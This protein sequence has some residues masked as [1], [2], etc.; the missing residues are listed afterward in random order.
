MNVA[1]DL[2]GIVSV[3][4]TREM[5]KVVYNPTLDVLRAV[6][7]FEVVAYHARALRWPGGFLGV[8]LFFCLSGFLISAILISEFLSSGR[9][10]LKRFY[11]HRAVRLVPGL[12]VML[13]G[14]LIFNLCVGRSPAAA[15][16]EVGIGLSGIANWIRAFQLLPFRDLAHLWSLAIEVQFYL[17][18][19]P[20]TFL[21]V[22]MILVSLP[23]QKFASLDATGATRTRL[24]VL[25]WSIGLYCVACLVLLPLIGIYRDWLI[26]S[27]ASF[28]R[29]Y[30]GTGVRFESFAMGAVIAAL[31]YGPGRTFERVRAA[32]TTFAPVLIVA[33]LALHF[34][35][36]LSVGP[37]D[38]RKS[39]VTMTLLNCSAASLIAG[40][41]FLKSGAFARML[42]PAG[43]VL[44]GK[45]S[46]GIYLWHYPLIRLIRFPKLHT[47]LR[48]LLIFALS[49]VLAA[50]SYFLVERPAIRFMRR[51]ETLKLSRVGKDL[52]LQ[53]SSDRDRER[54]NSTSPSLE[55]QLLEKRVIS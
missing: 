51:K 4:V 50:I 6:A 1:F 13:A 40:V 15:A 43:L 46:Y 23:R 31:A 16:R 27:R 36:V 38:W 20:L 5:Q 44:L 17:L 14:Y 42:H 54:I 11:L 45:L 22:R 8:D 37:A 34:N 2:N 26:D 49:T 47:D 29:L 39:T 41:V 25:P 9:I 21:L 12:I 28:V 52:T 18:W 10:D 53:L 55:E 3:Q 35:A 48:F 24:N 7:V 30:N 32:A 33:G 19:A